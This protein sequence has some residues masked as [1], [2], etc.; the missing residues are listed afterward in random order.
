MGV[1]RERRVVCQAPS[2]PSNPES[3]HSGYTTQDSEDEGLQSEQI[4]HRQ[5]LRTSRGLNINFNVSLRRHAG[6]RR[7]RR[8][9]NIKFLET[10]KEED[11]SDNIL[12][13]NKSKF[14]LLM[15]ITNDPIEFLNDYEENSCVIST[16]N[17]VNNNPYMN[18][19]KKIRVAIASKKD[20]RY[21]LLKSI[22]L[23]LTTFIYTHP[24]LLK[25][26]HFPKNCYE[27]FLV[28]AI[29]KYNGLQSETITV[30]SG[31]A[32]KVYRREEELLPQK[33]LLCDYLHQMK[34]INQ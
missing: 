19:P 6:Q 8:A 15:E 10:L 21:D 25:Y 24:P 7:V 22:E 20:F 2:I 28:H 9:L 1:V 29:A 33:Q 30:D 17:W 27:R 5:P 31:M 4:R 3:V 32:V 18:I 12:N 14:Q 13:G 26:Y 34:S 23:V 16:S 11:E